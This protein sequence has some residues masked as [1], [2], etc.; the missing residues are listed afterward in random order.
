MPDI[1]ALS[2]LQTITNLNSNVEERKVKAGIVDAHREAKKVLGTTLYDLVYATP[3][4]YTTLIGYLKYFM[5]WRAKERAVFDMYAEPD[6]AGIY[7]KEGN[8]HRALS[9][10]ELSELKSTYRSRADEYLEELIAYLDNNI[11]DYP[12]YEET[13]DCEERITSDNAKR[14]GG[15]SFRKSTR[16]PRYRG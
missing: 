5:A 9:G 13:V 16:Q 10:K 14:P 3:A 2:D 7:V 6:K 1:I 8:E 15:I 4:S 11:D 12:E